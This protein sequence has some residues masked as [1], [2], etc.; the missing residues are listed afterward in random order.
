MGDYIVA[1]ICQLT[2]LISKNFKTSYLAAQ[3]TNFGD[4]YIKILR[5]ASTFYVESKFCDYTSRK[6]ISIFND[7]HLYANAVKLPKKIWLRAYV[8]KNIQS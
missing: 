4:L 5:R 6:K 2:Y 8:I 3:W 1:Q 7:M